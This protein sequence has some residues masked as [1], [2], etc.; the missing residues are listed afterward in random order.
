MSETTTEPVDLSGWL[1]G[2]T[3]K[4]AA[5]G[6]SPALRVV[7]F[8]RLGDEPEWVYARYDDDGRSLFADCYGV[9][10]ADLVASALEALPELLR[11]A[12]EGEAVKRAVLELAEKLEEIDSKHFRA[13]EDAASRLRS[14]VSTAEEG[15]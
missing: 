4:L 13:Y 2:L 12:R 14:A 11:L 7:G 15:R 9:D 8:D 6:D 3:E 1:D 5:I 10:A